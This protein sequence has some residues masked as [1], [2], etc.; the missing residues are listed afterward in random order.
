MELYRKKEM[1]NRAGFNRML[2]ARYMEDDKFQMAHKIDI[3]ALGDTPLRAVLQAEDDFSQTIKLL[4][5]CYI[6]SRTVS[7]NPVQT[8]L[9]RMS[10][11]DQCMASYIDQYASIFSQSEKRAQRCLFV[12]DKR[13]QCCCLPLIPRIP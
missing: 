5:F 2:S 11:N 3:W 9:I 6:F 8:H 4:D 7:R 13:L 10:Y 12:N 1:F